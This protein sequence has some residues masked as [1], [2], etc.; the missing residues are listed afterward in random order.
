MTL[1]TLT[2]QE[3]ADV[4]DVFSVTFDQASNQAI[5][6]VDPL[7]NTDPKHIG[8]RQ[9]IRSYS[10]PSLKL[11]KTNEGV[12]APKSISS[13]LPETVKGSAYVM[14]SESLWSVSADTLEMKFVAQGITKEAKKATGVYDPAHDVIYI[15]GQGS[16]NDDVIRVSRPSGEITGSVRLP[17][18]TTAHELMIDSDNHKIIAM[19]SVDKRTSSAS[20]FTI[21]T[22]TF[23]VI[24]NETMLGN[25]SDYEGI[26]ANLDLQNRKVFVTD[27]SGSLYS[28]SLD[29][30]SDQ[31]R[32][33]TKLGYDKHQL[34]SALAK[35]TLYFL[36]EDG[37]LLSV[38]EDGK[39]SSEKI[40]DNGNITAKYFLYCESINSLLI[41]YSS[42]DNH[43]YLALVALNK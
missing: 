36:L 26:T 39:A 25:E 40:I 42:K 20:L 34:K 4:K 29:N 5:L 28:V 21:D 24:Q 19:G 17:T 9:E 11:S 6:I 10:L 7:N 2:N 22:E 31:N 30:F 12:Y 14:S 41:S 1:S 8:T 27:A 18:P 37:T 3:I 38:S 33:Y 13:A 16:F 15:T 35:Q 32:I 23:R 43:H